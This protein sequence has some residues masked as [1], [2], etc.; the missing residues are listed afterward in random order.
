MVLPPGRLSD[1]VS[2]LDA[3]RFGLSTLR[4]IHPRQSAPANLM[5]V[6]LRRDEQSKMRV[7][8]PL[9]VHDPDGGYTEEVDFRLRTAAQE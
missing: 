4:F 5:E 7:L 8:A 1:L 3:L 2:A 9:V 6:V